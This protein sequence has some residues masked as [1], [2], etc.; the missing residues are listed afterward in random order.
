M[1]KTVLPFNIFCGIL[2]TFS[3]S[4]FYDKQIILISKSLLSVFVLIWCSLHSYFTYNSASRLLYLNSNSV[5]NIAQPFYPKWLWPFD[6]LYLQPTSSTNSKHILSPVQHLC[7]FL[8]L[9]TMIASGLHIESND[10]NEI[11]L[12]IF[13]D[14]HLS[15][16]ESAGL[17]VA[18]RDSLSFTLSWIIRAAGVDAIIEKPAA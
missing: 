10:E 9:F 8:F 5:M 13:Q 17:W 11:N 16:S 6:I 7:C 3:C 1:L 4:R 15:H 2:G 14:K 12:Y 18:K